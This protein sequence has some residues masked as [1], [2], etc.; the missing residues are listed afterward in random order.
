MTN[1]RKSFILKHRFGVLLDRQALTG[2]KCYFLIFMGVSAFF[3]MYFLRKIP[4][5]KLS[6]GFNLQRNPAVITDNY[7]NTIRKRRTKKH[8]RQN[9]WSFAAC[10]KILYASD[11]NSPCRRSACLVSAV[12]S[13]MKQPSQPM[14][15]RKSLE[16]ALYLIPF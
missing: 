14:D 11:C 2:H 8:E 3:L 10:R 7:A 12:P 9:L 1:S 5:N 4:N 16:A 13:Q 6:E 15:Y